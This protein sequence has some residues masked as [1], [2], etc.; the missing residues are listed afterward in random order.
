MAK[1]TGKTEEITSVTLTL[2]KEEAEVI[3]LLTG[4]V[5][6]FHAPDVYGPSAKVRKVLMDA[7]IGM[8]PWADKYAYSLSI[9]RHPF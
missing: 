1:V 3:R 8:P 5:G 9:T 2:S 6:L 4:Q 7:G